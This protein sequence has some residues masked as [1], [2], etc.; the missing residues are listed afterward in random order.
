MRLTKLALVT[1][2]SSSSL[3]V[4]PAWSETTAPPLKTTP[5]VTQSSTAQT[6]ARPAEMSVDAKIVPTESISSQSPEPIK[7][8]AQIAQATQSTKVNT[9]E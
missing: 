4:K 6:P 1:L 9:E 7:I 2:I 8:P 3:L 5:E